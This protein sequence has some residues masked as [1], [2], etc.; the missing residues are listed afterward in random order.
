MGGMVSLWGANSSIRSIQYVSVS[1]TTAAESVTIAAVNVANTVVI[2]LGPSSAYTPG[3]SPS[4]SFATVNLVNSTTVTLAVMATGG[5]SSTK[6]A[7]VIEFAP[8]VVKSV[9]S[10]IATIVNSTASATATITGVNTAKTWI[11]MS[12]LTNADAGSVSGD[13]GATSTLTNA[14]TITFARETSAVSYYITCRFF[15]VE[16]F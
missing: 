14:T 5:Y 16:Y 9:Q 7:V 1:S 13:W 3:N 6:K 15:A 2:A 10:G 11:T 12:T 4:T 8:G